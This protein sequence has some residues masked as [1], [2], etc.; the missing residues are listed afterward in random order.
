MKDSELE[1]LLSR[2]DTVVSCLGHTL[3]IKG[4]YGK[5]RNLCVLTTQRVCGA[6]RRLK[7]A[8]P[9]RYIVVS[10]E[11]VSRPDGLDPKRT[12]IT[13]RVLLRL[14]ELL[15]PPHGDNVKNAAYLHSQVQG[16]PCVQFV[17]V[18]PSNLVNGDESQYAIYPTLQNGI[19][20]AGTTTRANVGSFMADLVTEPDVWKAWK[21][22]WPHILNAPAS[23]DTEATAVSPTGA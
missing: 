16:D 13:E 22:K 1:G 21:G 18:R 5:P 20:N 3:S 10:T 17:A 15:L 4:V 8:T 7:P 23:G 9:I 2:C 11:G 19:F 14:L 12:S 6:I